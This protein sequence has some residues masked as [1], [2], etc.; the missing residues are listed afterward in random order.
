M[1]QPEDV[2]H[3]VEMLVTQSSAIVCE[4]DY[5]E[6]D[7][8]T[9]GEGWCH[10]DRPYFLNRFSN[11]WRA[12]LGAGWPAWKFLFPASRAIRRT[13]N[14]CATSFLAPAPAPAACTRSGCQDRSTCTACRSAVRSRTWDKVLSAAF[15][16][17]PCRI[18]R[19]GKPRA[20][21]A[22]SPALAPCCS[23]ACWRTGAGFSL[24]FLAR[25]CCSRSRS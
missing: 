17:A 7:A 19:S 5:S 4:R 9:V 6:A 2:A 3:A 12:S 18:A 1:L 23:R 13:C 25:L 16:A 22:Y 24:R 10:V 20:C 21:P 11:A 15:P 8:E 14:R